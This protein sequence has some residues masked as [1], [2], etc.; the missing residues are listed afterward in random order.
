MKY[1]FNVCF[2]LKSDITTYKRE[3]NSLVET[4]KQL[5]IKTGYILTKDES[6]FIE[7]DN[8]KIKLIS[9]FEFFIFC[10]SK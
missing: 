4:M 7:I 1:I 5:K 9:V 6:D 8:H 3:V 10:F 2:S